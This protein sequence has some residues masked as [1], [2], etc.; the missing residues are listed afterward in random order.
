MSLLN[1]SVALT[2]LSWGLF[3]ILI[4]VCWTISTYYT[5]DVIPH[6]ALG[7]GIIL[8]GLNM[9]RVSFGMSLSKLS[10]FIG[11]V[12]LA[13]GGSALLG[14]KLPLLQTILILIGLFI[15]AEA[16]RSLIKS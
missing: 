8:I 1:K 16:V 3:F 5:I 4:G 12:A 15:I 9:A 14:Q 11:L 6:V 2:S 10:L 13:I 7:T